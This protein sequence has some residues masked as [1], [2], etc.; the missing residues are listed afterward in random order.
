MRRIAALLAAA[1][2]VAVGLGIA[3]ANAYDGRFAYGW[4]NDNSRSEAWREHEWRWRAW[5]HHEWRVH[6]WYPWRYSSNRY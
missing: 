3:P 2:V 6:H 1:T 4:H 5:Y